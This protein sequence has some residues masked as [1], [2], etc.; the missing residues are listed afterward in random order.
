VLELKRK[1]MVIATLALT[2]L[3]WVGRAFPAV[4]MEKYVARVGI[5][6]PQVAEVSASIAVKGTP[7]TAKS[8]TVVCRLVRYPQ[9]EIER[10]E[11][12]DGA[13]RILPVTILSVD[14]ALEARLPAGSEIPNQYLVLYSVTSTRQLRRIP[15]AVVD[16][17]PST[18]EGSVELQT[19]LSA[20]YVAAGSSFPAM[21]WRD[22][23]HGFARLNA[24]PS[25][26][27]LNAKHISRVSILDRLLDMSTI[28]TLLMF[29]FV[30]VSSLVW[31]LRSR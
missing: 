20:D 7:V 25:V 28:S 23:Q 4:Q 15:L 26:V 3:L 8:A 12:E 18:A 9:Q 19:I 17:P 11:V 10:F 21:E 2:T 31:Y 6:S 5:S 30:L 27:V 14:G 16:V 1:A 13:G 29:S 24:I 22:R